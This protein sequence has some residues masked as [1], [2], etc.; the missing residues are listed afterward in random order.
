MKYV[1]AFLL[2]IS[3]P[4]P[5]FAADAVPDAATAEKLGAAALKAKLGEYIYTKYMLTLTWAAMKQGD[6]Y[7]LA[8]PVLQ[9]QADL[10]LNQLQGWIVQIDRHDGHIIGVYLQY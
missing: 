2:F 9:P 6:D 8:M 3:M 1:F 10:N 5:A 7:W 4:N